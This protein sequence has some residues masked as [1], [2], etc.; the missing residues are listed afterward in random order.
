M[1]PMLVEWNLNYMYNCVAISNG[2]VN[3]LPWHSYVIRDQPFCSVV[4]PADSG[5]S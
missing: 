4:Q 3:A 5:R 1:I 2:N